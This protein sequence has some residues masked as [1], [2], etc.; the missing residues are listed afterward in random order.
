M[1]HKNAGHPARVLFSTGFVPGLL[2]T[3]VLQEHELHPVR[4]V[5]MKTMK[6]RYLEY[7]CDGVVH[8]IQY[9]H[10][11]KK[12]GRVIQQIGSVSID[13]NHLM[14]QEHVVDASRELQQF[15]I[16]SV[17]MSILP[18]QW[19]QYLSKRLHAVPRELLPTLDEVCAAFMIVK[20]TERAPS[21]VH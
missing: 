8:L 15:Y 4:V 17:R 6:E 16:G 3:L 18:L 20:I 19:L 10:S 13:L 5:D 12:K 14:Q 11:E 7:G 2:E 9:I 21:A 1:T